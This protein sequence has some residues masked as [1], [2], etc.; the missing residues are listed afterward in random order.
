MVTKVS[1]AFVTVSLPALCK[2][3]GHGQGLKMWAIL[4]RIWWILI[5]DVDGDNGPGKGQ[6]L[7]QTGRCEC[8]K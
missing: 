1:N 5:E 7:R 3:P 8:E 4:S 2:L 6:I